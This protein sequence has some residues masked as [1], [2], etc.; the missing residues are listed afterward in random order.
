MER[1]SKDPAAGEDTKGRRDRAWLRSDLTSEVR[2]SIPAGLR[3]NALLSQ[4]QQQQQQR[5][6]NAG[7]PTPR[8]GAAAL[9]PFSVLRPFYE[10]RVAFFVRGIRRGILTG[11]DW[12]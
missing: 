1:V 10:R 12:T 9:Q 3:G 5:L 6:N 2:V 7:A 4:Q 8:F 11:E